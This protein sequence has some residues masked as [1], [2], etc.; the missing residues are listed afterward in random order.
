MHRYKAERRTMTKEFKIAHI[1]DCHLGYRSG[2]FRDNET[3]INLREQD[4]YDALDKA[5]D[6]IIEA[7]PDVV[8]CSGDMF[9][10][11]KPSIYTIIQCKKILQKLVHL[12]T[13]SI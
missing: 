12:F 13:S 1:S 7:K 8:I 10:S 11:P 9:H 2:Q 3:G 6:E 4:G 5:I